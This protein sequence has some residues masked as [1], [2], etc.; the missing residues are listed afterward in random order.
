VKLIRRIRRG[1][2]EENAQQGLQRFYAAPGSA[3]REVACRR[4]RRGI[5]EKPR[6]KEKELIETRGGFLA[7][8][9]LLCRPQPGPTAP[10]THSPGAASGRSRHHP[11]TSHPRSATLMFARPALR[12]R[13]RWKSRTRGDHQQPRYPPTD[14]TPHS[15]GSH[16][17]GL[18]DL[19]LSGKKHVARCPPHPHWT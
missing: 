1:Y 14:W 10:Y 13:C 2:E 8:A 18:T 4:P 15:C 7:R 6:D 16:Y 9:G 3:R 17:I 12:T 5:A 11:R 19:R